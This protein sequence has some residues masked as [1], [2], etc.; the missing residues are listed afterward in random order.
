[1]DK[2]IFRKAIISF[3]LI[4]FLCTLLGVIIVQRRINADKVAMESLITEKVAIINETLQYAANMAKT[5]SSIFSLTTCDFEHFEQV[6]NAFTDDSIVLNVLIAPGGVVSNVYPI[7][8][9]ERVLGWCF[10][11]ENTDGN[12]EAVRAIEERQLV[13]AGPF[14]KFQDVKVLASRMPIFVSGVDGSEHFWGLVVI[15]L[16][17][18]QFVER[19]GLDNFYS[20]D[21]DF[22]IWR[23]NPD[24]GERQT[25]VGV[26]NRSSKYIER[27]VNVQNAGWYFR[28]YSPR[29]WYTNGETWLLIFGGLLLSFLAA[30]LVQRNDELKIAKYDLQ[31]LTGRLS[32]MAVK[33]LEGSNRSFRDIMFEEEM[34]I[35][36]IVKADGISVFRNFAAPDGLHMTQLYCCK[37]GPDNSSARFPRF[38]EGTYDKYIPNWQKILKAN[39]AINGPVRLMFEPEA[40][41]MKSYGIVSLFAAP[42]F[43]SDEFWG[44]VLFED[45]SSEKYFDSSHAKFMHSAAFLF[46][47]AIIRSEMETFIAQK[48]MEVRGALEQA[49]A[50]NQV[51]SEFLGRMSHE[52]LTP[53]NAII[54]MTQIANMSA[55]LD[56]V[57]DCL[58]E[59]DG[60]S[61]HLVR[62]IS[63]VL[64]I[65][66]GSETFGLKEREFSWDSMLECILRRINPDIDR[67]RQVLALDIAAA[68]PAWLIGDERRLA[69]V[70]IH[71]LGNAVKFT[72]EFGEIILR[73]GVLEQKNNAIT[74]QIGIID[75]GIGI[76]REEQKNL[77]AIF[78]QV[79]GSYTRKH[80][81]MGIGLPLAKYIVQMMD[82]NI[83]VESELGKGAK[84]FFTCKLTIP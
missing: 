20:G 29:P 59:I 13:L 76:S 37:R 68:V 15:N 74:F 57:K 64:D 24:R 82:G 51:K 42:V 1:M 45:H 10:F 35:A 54:G 53:M 25:I 52:M 11:S 26:N 21:F 83:W 73:A 55:S 2:K 7:E 5:I 28:V 8:G 38:P 23:V 39:E 80:G 40:S 27:Y 43:I 46:A 78:E 72:P 79:D 12:I 4:L 31:N 48:N 19:T 30:F 41:V 81:G 6:A 9:N 70:V 17:Y 56:K 77:F 18:T 69:Q 47:T 22:E 14:Y 75:N 60:A 65:S 66:G 49:V 36:D 62:M 34:H 3:L 67:K 32:K 44:F 84:F 63:N 71:L 33:F 50:A 58:S 16:V 61:R